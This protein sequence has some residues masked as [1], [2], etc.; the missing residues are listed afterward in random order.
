MQSL[1]ANRDSLSSCLT[2]SFAIFL[3]RNLINEKVP[4]QKAGH[5]HM[6]Q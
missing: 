2:L 4:E 1:A 5:A 6:E 3:M